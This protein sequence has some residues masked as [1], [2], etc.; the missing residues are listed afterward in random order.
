M[1][2]SR[3]CGLLKGTWLL[4]NSRNC[5]A[6]VRPGRPY[7]RGNSFGFYI[8]NQK[9]HPQPS[10]KCGFFMPVS[11]PCGLLKGTWLLCNSRTRRNTVRFRAHFWAWYEFGFFVFSCESVLQLKTAGLTKPRGGIAY[12]TKN[13]DNLRSRR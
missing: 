8:P 12:D 3:P 7:R 5:P 11:R 10:H 4:I 13:R 9:R 2:V 1:P 6:T